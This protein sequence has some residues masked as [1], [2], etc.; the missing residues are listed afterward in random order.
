MIIDPKQKLR[1]VFFYNNLLIIVC[2]FCIVCFI[3]SIK[4]ENAS[5]DANYLLYS[6]KD[7]LYGPII[8]KKNKPTILEATAAFSGNN[9]SSYVSGE[10]IKN[11]ETVYEFDKDLWHESGYDGGEYYSESDAHLNA[12]LTLKEPGTYY[13]K[14]NNE[15]NNY[16]T[17]INLRKKAASGIP[18]YALGFCAFIATFILFIYFNLDWAKTT[19]QK[20]DEKFGDA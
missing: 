18:H 7:M 11:G 9:S 2:V 1:N 10:V 5:R 3:T 6:K 17:R 20:I 14:L 15:D 8:V 16:N 4:L 12:K 13:I 19:L